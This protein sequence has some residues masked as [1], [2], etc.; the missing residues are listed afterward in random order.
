QSVKRSLAG[1]G[2]PSDRR[3]V[4]HAATCSVCGCYSAE[5]L[6][7]RRRSQQSGHGLQAQRGTH[8]FA[9]RTSRSHPGSPARLLPMAFYHERLRVHRPPMTW[10]EGSRSGAFVEAERPRHPDLQFALG[11]VWQRS[12]CELTDAVSEPQVCKCDVLRIVDD[13]LAER[14]LKK[15]CQLA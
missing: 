8:G 5:L 3:S 12:P 9:D 15:H 2:G 7:R 4:K 6:G 13:V 1:E 10:L 11:D 14:L